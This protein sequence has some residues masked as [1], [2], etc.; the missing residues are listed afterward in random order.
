MATIYPHFIFKE[1]IKEVIPFY[2]DI[3]ETKIKKDIFDAQA[4]LIYSVIRNEENVILISEEEEWEESGNQLEFLLKVNSIEK[5]EEIY[6]KLAFEGK[7]ITKFSRRYWAPAYAKVIDKFG[8]RWIIDVDRNEINTITI[9]PYLFFNGNS[10]K[11]IAFYE[12]VFNQNAI[13]TRLSEWGTTNKEERDLIAHSVIS[14]DDFELHISDYLREEEYRIG[15]Q[16]RLFA[17][18]DK[19]EELIYLCKKLSQKANIRLVLEECERFLFY[20]ILTD[21]FNVIWEVAVKK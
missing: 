5:A 18:V 12:E 6:K 21:E 11:A 3:F 15:K 4:N 7:I 2:E 8:V 17:S 10:D 13:S 20:A 1:N 19:L 16:H 9:I 14:K